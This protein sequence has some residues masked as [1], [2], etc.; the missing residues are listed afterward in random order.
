M[1]DIF[2][3]TAIYSWSSNCYQCLNSIENLV[4]SMVIETHQTLLPTWQNYIFTP[5][6]YPSFVYRLILNHLSL[7][8]K[9]ADC[10][11]VPFYFPEYRKSGVCD[12]NLSIW[13]AIFDAFDVLH[14]NAT[15]E[16]PK[17]PL[18]TLLDL[19][20]HELIISSDINHWTRKH[21]TFL[22]GQFFIFDI[23]QKR[24]R[25]RVSVEYTRY[26]RLCQ[27][28]FI[29]ILQTRL[30]KLQPNVWP[31]I[32][33]DSPPTTAWPDHSM[34]TAVSESSV[35]KYYTSRTY[36]EDIQ[37]AS[38]IP[39]R[40]TST[41]IKTFWMCRM[42]P[43]ARTLYFRCFS[44]CIPTKKVLLKYGIT[45]SSTC[46]L[47]GLH[48]DT[49]RHFLVECRI[50]WDIW[51]QVLK[52][53]FPHIGLSSEDIYSSLRKLKV[54]KNI[55]DSKKYFSVLSTTLYQLWIIYWQHGND[56]LHPFSLSQVE[57]S[58]QR[59]I[60]HIERLLQSTEE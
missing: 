58:L 56:N 17:L 13:N 45:S 14:T 48:T 10:P 5:N 38:I 44:K 50:K 22:S 7:F 49:K 40:F 12:V 11:L 30:I 32:L 60:T 47:C 51:K 19:P 4:L 29:D 6:T 53:Y 9:S 23:T 25:L 33:E 36:R 34:V 8:L 28:L 2:S 37:K 54:P 31:H 3:T 20:L 41:V 46:S 15:L 59:I 55:S 57:P 43:N 42:Y 16:F 1:S 39:V 26:P 35:W 21:K 18:K 24:L 52:E 27:Q